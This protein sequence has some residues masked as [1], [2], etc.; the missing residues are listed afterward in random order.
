MG[1]GGGRRLQTPFQ[2]LP[3]LHPVG[4]LG[5][6]WGCRAPAG[7]TDV[8]AVFVEDTSIFTVT[9]NYETTGRGI[10]LCIPAC[11]GSEDKHREF[12]GDGQAPTS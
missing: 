10:K 4:E 1:G 5:S 7:G 3:S 6:V 2:H 12:T 9:Q 11:T 8:G